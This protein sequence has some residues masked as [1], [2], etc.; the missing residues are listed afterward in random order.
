[1]IVSCPNCN[2]KFNIEAKLIPEKGRLLLCSICNH[3]WHYSV[4]KNESEIDKSKIFS[5]NEISEAN[6]E[7]QK[8]KTINKTYEKI[9]SENQD[10]NISKKKIYK[11]YSLGNLL[12]NL[13]IILITFTAFILIIDT[14]KNNISN[15]FPALIP[16]LDNLYQSLIDF[17]TI[18][19]D[20][21]K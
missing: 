7:K 9:K 18:I 19:K 13:I 5:I 20:L 10:S 8:R 4:P 2:K 14:F 6:I 1:M 12:I 17:F 15:Y 21:F 3:K 16:V 11:N